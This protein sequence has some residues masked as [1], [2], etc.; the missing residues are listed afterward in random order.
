MA[1]Y[2]GSRI[3]DGVDLVIRPGEAVALLGRNG[4]GKTTLLRAIT[5]TVRADAGRI[6]LDGA[7][8]ANQAA[9]RINRRGI[10]LAPEG[11]RLFPNLTVR[12]NLVLAARPGGSSVEAVFA[13]F[14]RLRERQG[15]RAESLSGGE[16]QMGA[17]A[18]TL[19]APA[20]LLLLDEPFEGLAPAIVADLV[21]ALL[22]L[23][24]RVAILLVEHHAGA[25]LPLVDRATVLVNGRVAFEGTSA[26]LAGDPALQARLLGVVE[27]ERRAPVPAA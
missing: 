4:A 14:P 16:R 9:F 23:R 6:L 7:D 10:A 20:R 21:A 22:T 15:V 18:R 13:L 12:E 25:V 24:G 5:G 19:M 11:R 2:A 1:G 27:Q 8:I 17:I 26:A 3:L